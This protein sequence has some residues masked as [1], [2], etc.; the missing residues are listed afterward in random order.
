MKTEGGEEEGRIA[1]AGWRGRV[2]RLAAAAGGRLTEVGSAL[3]DLAV[4]VAVIGVAYTLLFYLGRFGWITYG[5]TQVGQLFVATDPRAATVAAAFAEGWRHLVPLLVA[6]AT[7][8]TVA[9]AAIARLLLLDHLYV[10]VG[11]LTGRFLWGGGGAAIG[12][13]FLE[14]Q[15]GWG[16]PIDLSLL[17]LPATA[18][19]LRAARLAELLLP[20]PLLVAHDASTAARRAARRWWTRL[21]GDEAAEEEGD[22]PT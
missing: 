15:G 4:V 18:L 8:G 3:L 14:R 20:D 5:E 13:L 6:A 17:L 22:G 7:A 1:S 21:G 11:P 2:G 9:A 10:W 16:V 12:A 19:A